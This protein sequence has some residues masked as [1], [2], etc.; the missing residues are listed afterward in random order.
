MVYVEVAMTV[1]HL[2]IRLPILR[3]HCSNLAQ[4]IVNAQNMSMPAWFNKRYW[5]YQR[6]FGVETEKQIDEIERWCWQNFK[7]KYW[8]SMYRAFAFKRERDFM[9]FTLR[10]S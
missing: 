5:P 1:N 4:D 2:P 6:Y 8:R 3:M 10:W 7:G 9:L